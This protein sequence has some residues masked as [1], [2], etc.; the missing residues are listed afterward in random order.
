MKKSICQEASA[1]ELADVLMQEIEHYETYLEYL[2][3]DEERMVTLRTE[4]LEESNKAKATLLMKI[5]TMEQARK[6]IVEKISTE[7]NIAAD[8]VKLRDLCKHLKVDDGEILLSLRERLIAVVEKIRK[9][10]LEASYLVASSL[11]W[12]D[13]SM[14]TLKQMLMPT[15]VYNNTGKVNDKSAFS[16]RVVENKA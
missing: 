12:V 3:G 1:Q 16:G 14:A 6:K 2:A 8:Q 4:E 9:V 15:G 11:T 13:G 5:Q 7:K 10:Q